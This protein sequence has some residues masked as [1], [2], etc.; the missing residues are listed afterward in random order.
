MKKIISLSNQER[1]RNGEW[2]N[3]IL[4]LGKPYGVVDAKKE[5]VLDP[6]TGKWFEL[7]ARLGDILIELTTSCGDTK[8]AKTIREAELFK[9]ANPNSKFVVGLKK[10]KSNKGKGRVSDGLDSH[11]DHLIKHPAIDNVLLGEEEIIKFFIKP[12]WNKQEKINKLKNNNNNKKILSNKG[13]S[14]MKFDQLVIREAIKIS[15][16]DPIEFLLAYGSNS[17]TYVGDMNSMSKLEKR[18]AKQID[19]RVSLCENALTLLDLKGEA[20]QSVRQLAET[21]GKQADL[22]KFISSAMATRMIEDNVKMVQNTDAKYDRDRWHIT[23][24]VIDK[25]GHHYS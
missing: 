8:E 6:L 17:T 18:K 21:Y 10:I 22:G 12:F 19:R 25:Y 16:M 1:Y 20:T 4:E 7:D 13:E 2:E 14:N 5:R 9:K 11:Y 15:D 3:E 24:S 23:Q